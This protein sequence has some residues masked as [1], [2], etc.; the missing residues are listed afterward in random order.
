M[1]PSPAK[2]IMLSLILSFL[3]EKLISPAISEIHRCSQIV[4][5]GMNTGRRKWYIWIQR[6]WEMCMMAPPHWMTGTLGRIPS[7]RWASQSFLPTTLG[8]TYYMTLPHRLWFA[9]PQYHPG[10]TQDPGRAEKTSRLWVWAYSIPHGLLGSM[11]NKCQW[12][13]SVAFCMALSRGMCSSLFPAAQTQ[14]RIKIHWVPVGISLSL[15]FQLCHHRQQLTGLKSP[16]W[17]CFLLHFNT[18]CAF[19][20][21]QLRL[22]AMFTKFMQIHPRVYFCLLLP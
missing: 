5:C 17:S 13:P 15:L 21:S 16:G 22:K 4:P 6:L 14:A 18:V 10:D 8:A 2:L 20:E 9:F 11:A 12:R 3:A 7:S 1:L 19:H